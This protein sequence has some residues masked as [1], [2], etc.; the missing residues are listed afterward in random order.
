VITI[1]S[2]P[3]LIKGVGEYFYEQTKE[4]IAANCYSFV[5]GH[6]SGVDLTRCVFKA[7]PVSWAATEL[8]CFNWYIASKADFFF[9]A[10]IRLKSKGDGDEYTALG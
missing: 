2:S 9:K 5:D 4:L 10:G 1:L 3:D 6:T 7:L 8:V